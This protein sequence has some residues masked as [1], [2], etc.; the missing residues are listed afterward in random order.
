MCVYQDY[1]CLVF[2]GGFKLD[3]QISRPDLA[4][5]ARDYSHWFVI[6]VELVSH[7]LAGH[8][9][10]QVRA[11]QYGKPQPD[12]VSI[13]ARETGLAEAQVET[14]LRVVPRSVAVVAN[15]RSRDWELSLGSLQVQLLTVSA[16]RSSSG[17]EAVEVGGNLEVLQEHLGFGTFSAT[18]R[19][20]RFPNTVRLPDGEIVITDVN[21][22]GTLWTVSRDGQYAW[23]TKNVGVPDLP[24]GGHIQLI[25]AFGGNIS[26]RRSTFD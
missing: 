26:I 3:E 20:L 16:Y 12:C 8:V 2:G 10:P 25:R 7:S 6:E 21:G 23:V 17:I 22:A 14:F 9:L 5:I 1:R 24:N 15:K 19:T 11:F 4:L 13:L 18:D